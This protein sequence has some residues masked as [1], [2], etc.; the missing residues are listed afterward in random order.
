[1]VCTRGDNQLA[2]QRCTDDQSREMETGDTYPNRQTY[3]YRRGYTET[4]RIHWPTLR[5]VGS[6]AGQSSGVLADNK[7]KSLSIMAH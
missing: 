3:L 6:T 5:P 7:K 2:I 1:M 4:H